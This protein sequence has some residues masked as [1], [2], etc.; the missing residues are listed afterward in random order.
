M[1]FP[2]R[3]GVG[4]NPELA[5]PLRLPVRR[6]S[7]LPG[8]MATGLHALPPWPS[9]PVV[10]QNVLVGEVWLCSGQSNMQ[11]P[12]AGWFK[13]KNLAHAL[14]LAN[15]P[16]IRLY[17]VPMIETNF[18]GTPRKLAPAGTVWHRCTPRNAAGFTAVGY[19]F[20]LALHKKLGVPIGLIEADWGGTNIEAWIPA[21]GFFAVPQLKADQTWLRRVE[22]QRRALDQRY[23]RAMEAWRIAA[24]RAVAAGT[25]A[26]KKPKKP[27]DPISASHAFNYQIP[28]KDWQPDGHQNPTTLF[29][30]MISPL[31]PYA[32]RGSIWYQGENNVP[33]HDHLYYQHLKAL[34]GSW[35]KLWG[36]GNFPF[37]IVQIAPYNYGKDGP[38]EP[39]IWQAQEMA[40]RRIS[41]CGI[42]GTMDI[43]N[44]HNVHPENKSAV[45]RRLA[46]I[47]LARTYHV[48]GINWS[49]PVF[50]SAA[51]HGNTVVLHFKHI[52]GGLASRNSRPL[53]WFQ[54]SG[55]NHKFLDA[56]ARI[57]GDTVVVHAASVP[58]PTAVRFAWNCVAQPNLMNKAGLPALPFQTTKP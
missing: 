54:V 57:V 4:P 1:I 31:I 30:G 5:L 16:N 58:E 17:H 27:L 51:F 14:A 44:I 15:H 56:Q 42:A 13:R 46:R 41:H 3:C 39:V 21:Q 26:P 48:K 53:T 40:A 12:M 22:T 25:A 6:S 38:M 24:R 36:E 37:Y 47:A 8:L 11:Y 28:P 19:F 2:H 9:A 55:K 20:G 50:A 34:I 43:G 45:G 10:I 23:T 32:I 49:G 29:N 18:T 35:R 52:A 33:S 7:Q